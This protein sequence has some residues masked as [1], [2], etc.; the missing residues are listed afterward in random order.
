MTVQRITHKDLE[1]HQKDRFALYEKLAIQVNNRMVQHDINPMTG[2]NWDIVPEELTEHL[3]V[4][5]A[6]LEISRMILA[7]QTLNVSTVS[8]IYEEFKMN[9]LL[10]FYGLDKESFEARV[11]DLDMLYMDYFFQVFMALNHSNPSPLDTVKCL[12]EH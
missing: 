5:I 4:D 2:V 3:R 12:T 11:V 10:A 9:M 6:H 7:F 8:R 1:G